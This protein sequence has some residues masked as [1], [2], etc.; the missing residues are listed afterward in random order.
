MLMAPRQTLAGFDGEILSVATPSTLLAT[1]GLLSATSAE[2][3]G[4]LVSAG[5]SQNMSTVIFQTPITPSSVLG[6][7]FVAEWQGATRN[8]KGQSGSR[9][10]T[11]PM[12]ACFVFVLNPNKCCYRTISSSATSATR[13][14]VRSHPSRMLRAERI[15]KALDVLKGR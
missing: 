7:P 1:P 4:S 14:N 10:D 5:S 3:C 2:D 9:M 11:D 15:V 12:L 8:E 13:G 6:L